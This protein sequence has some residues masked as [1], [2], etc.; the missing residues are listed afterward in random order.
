MQNMQETKIRVILV[1]QLFLVD[2]ILILIPESW[3]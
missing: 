1:H 3:N 2:H